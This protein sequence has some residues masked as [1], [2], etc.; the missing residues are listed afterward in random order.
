MG[1]TALPHADLLAGYKGAYF[2]REGRGRTGRKGKEGGEGR[3]PTS[4][5]RG[6]EE[7]G[8]KGRE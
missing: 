1:P 3:G 5:A 7:R 2:L 4:K 6:R 8:G